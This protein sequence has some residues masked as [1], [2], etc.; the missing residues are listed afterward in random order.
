MENQQT[1]A[2][3][4]RWRQHTEDESAARA[5]QQA[6]AGP[7]HRPVGGPPPYGNEQVNL[8]AAEIKAEEREHCARLVE[9]WPVGSDAKAADLLRQ[10]AAALR[11]PR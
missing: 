5:A 6:Q 2:A 1:D 4:E 10:V 9:T 7:T 8:V 11:R 3:N